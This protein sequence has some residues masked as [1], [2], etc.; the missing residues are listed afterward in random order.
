[1]SAFHENIAT[2]HLA[3]YCEPVFSITCGIAP[4]IKLKSGSHNSY[5]IGTFEGEKFCR[6]V[7]RE[8]FTD[9]LA[10]VGHTRFVTLESSI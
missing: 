2:H 4:P 1:M 10:M 6:S 8:Y 7:G 9:K 5:I 3:S